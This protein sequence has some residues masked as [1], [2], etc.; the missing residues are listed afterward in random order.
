MYCFTEN[1]DNIEKTIDENHNKLLLLRDN[2]RFRFKSCLVALLDSARSEIRVFDIGDHKRN[3]H[4]EEVG[5]EMSREHTQ[6]LQAGFTS[7]NPDGSILQGDMLVHELCQEI[8][9]FAG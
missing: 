7:A 9:S 3:F 1:C 4:R 2:G 5:T 8:F 6:I